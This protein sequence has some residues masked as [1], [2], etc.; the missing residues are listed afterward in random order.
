[1]NRL[2]SAATAGIWPTFGG[3][4]AQLCWSR[5]QWEMP[6]GLT[7]SLAAARR[8]IWVHHSR[9]VRA[10]WGRPPV[11]IPDPKGVA[12]RAEPI[13]ERVLPL[14]RRKA[15]IAHICDHEPHAAIDTQ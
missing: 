14:G 5:A 4:L 15:E 6:P 3:R 11:P 1:M 2:G 10:F 9:H 12:N 7:P 8:R 13:F